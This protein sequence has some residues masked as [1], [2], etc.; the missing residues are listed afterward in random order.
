M[1][2]YELSKWPSNPIACWVNFRQKY[3]F[4]IDYCFLTTIYERE[5]HVCIV[6]Q[7]TLI[8]CSQIT[9]A[10]VDVNIFF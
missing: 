9:V 10:R 8:H 3:T 1:A 5:I 4:N 2:C 6:E 7:N